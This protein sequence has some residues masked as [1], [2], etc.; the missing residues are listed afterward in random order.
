MEKFNYNKI[1]KKWFKE[2]VCDKCELCDHD[3]Y[4]E[5]KLINEHTGIYDFKLCHLCEEKLREFIGKK[6]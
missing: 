4:S 3:G 6:D 1:E 5:Y 2:E